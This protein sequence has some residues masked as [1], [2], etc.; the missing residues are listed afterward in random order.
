MQPRSVAASLL[1]ALM[2]ATLGVLQDLG[3]TVNETSVGA[4]MINGCKDRQGARIRVS[5]I[6]R[7]TGDRAAMIA[8]VSFQAVVASLFGQQPEVQTISDPVIYQRFFERLSQ[9]LFSKPNRYDSAN[10]ASG[11]GHHRGV[12]LM[13]MTVTMRPRGPKQ[14]V[15]RASAQ[16]N[17]ASVSDAMPY[18]Q[19]FNLLEKAMFLTAN[20]ID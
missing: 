20:Q 15:V 7:P 16:Y 6:V 4:G 19:F 3:S 9:S 8:R 18:R 12:C 17:K 11:S 13:R 10:V 5:V 1:L 2:A 14:M